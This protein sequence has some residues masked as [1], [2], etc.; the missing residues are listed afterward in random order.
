MFLNNLMCIVQACPPLVVPRQRVP[1]RREASRRRLA[2][3]RLPG[4]GVARAQRVQAVPAG[5]AGLPAAAAEGVRGRGHLHLR[6]PSV[7]RSPGCELVTSR[8]RV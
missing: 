5:R 3:Q 4:A 6:R 7:L 8:Y 1:E 2:G